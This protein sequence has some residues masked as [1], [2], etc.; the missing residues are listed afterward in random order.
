GVSIRRRSW[1]PVWVGP[2]A[3]ANELPHL[4]VGPVSANSDRAPLDALS[5]GEFV[6]VAAFEVVLDDSPM[7]GVELVERLANELVVRGL[8]L[9][10]LEPGAEGRRRGSL[11]LGESVHQSS[12][13]PTLSKL[14]LGLEASDPL[15][16]ATNRLAGPHLK[17]GELA[18]DDHQR[19]LN[20]ILGVGLV[21]EPAEARTDRSEEHTSELQSRENLVCR[22]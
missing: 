21:E 10:T 2:A 20:Q 18:V 9:G 8:L 6:D 16:P 12:P 22:L 13:S 15:R 7:A 11:N 14:L 17:L 19:D 3:L 1:R 4:F 5:L